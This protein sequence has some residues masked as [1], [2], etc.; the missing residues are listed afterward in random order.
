MLLNRSSFDS[1]YESDK[2]ASNGFLI[3]GSPFYCLELQRVLIRSLPTRFRCR[4]VDNIF[5]K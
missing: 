3:L 5:I 4:F 1:K 2:D